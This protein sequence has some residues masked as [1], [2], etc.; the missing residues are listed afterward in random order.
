MADQPTTATAPPLALQVLR[1]SVAATRD[2]RE[3]LIAT[4]TAWGVNRASFIRFLKT[5][6]WVPDQP[7][8]WL[9]VGGGTLI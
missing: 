7:I 5:S 4:V 2:M 1:L 9:Q 6:P 8:E 3:G